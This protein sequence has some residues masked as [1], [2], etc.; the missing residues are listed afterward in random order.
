[1]SEKMKSKIHQYLISKTDFLS[2]KDKLPEDKLRS[3]VLKAIQDV[4]AKEEID[5]TETVQTALVREIVSAVISFGPIRSLMEDKTVS[6]IMI[7]GPRQ[8]FVQKN[9]HIQ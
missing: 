8:V 4:C 1:M 7:N 6:E 9:G 2:V 5:L 3:F